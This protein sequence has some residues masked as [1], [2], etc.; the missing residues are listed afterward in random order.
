MAYGQRKFKIRVQRRDASSSKPRR[1]S[2][3]SQRRIVVNGHVVKAGQKT[4]LTKPQTA[5]KS[6]ISKPKI[7]RNPAGGK[8]Q[9]SLS[10]ANVKAGRINGSKR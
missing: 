7:P 3:V 2:L 8:L 9:A 5:L 4:D 1:I 6:M 10:K